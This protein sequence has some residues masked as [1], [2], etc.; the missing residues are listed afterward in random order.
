MQTFKGLLD[1]G[2]ELTVIT[3]DPEC[4]CG[5]PGRIEAYGSQSVNGILAH[6]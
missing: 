4:H 3:R 1:I 6:I 2:S 5:P